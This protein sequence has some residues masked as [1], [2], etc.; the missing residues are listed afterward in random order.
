MSNHRYYFQ[1]RFD[2][3]EQDC[4]REEVVFLIEGRGG[5]A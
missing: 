5:D 3:M 4:Q 2:M 1:A